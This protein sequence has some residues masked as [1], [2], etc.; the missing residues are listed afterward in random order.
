MSV[1]GSADERTDPMPRIYGDCMIAEERRLTVTEAYEAAY[2][3]VWQYAEREPSNEALQLLLV[4]M[5]P[6]DDAQRTND[7]ASWPD[8][9]ACVSDVGR[10]AL[11]R[12]PQA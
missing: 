9:V 2:R 5:E 10:T 4:S 8:W 1:A 7:P 12:F 6:T 11:L 3:F